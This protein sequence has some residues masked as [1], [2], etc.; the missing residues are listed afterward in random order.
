MCPVAFFFFSNQTRPKTLSWHPLA[1]CAGVWCA[2]GTR[3][4]C[5]AHVGHALG[6]C[7]ARW[8]CI[9]HALGVLGALLGHALDVHQAWWALHGRGTRGG[10]M[11]THCQHVVFSPG[12]CEHE[13]NPIPGFAFFLFSLSWSFFYF[14]FCSFHVLHFFLFYF[15]FC[16]LLLPFSQQ[17]AGEFSYQCWQKRRYQAISWKGGGGKGDT[18]V[19]L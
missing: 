11:L 17:Q 18:C 4:V 16:F 14:Y 1:F 8:A 3:W 13:N 6:M 15:I 2:L 9:G 5:W 7:W 10:C 19:T 12:T